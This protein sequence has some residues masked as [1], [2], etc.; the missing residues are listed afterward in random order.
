MVKAPLSPRRENHSR[1]VCDEQTVSRVKG[2]PLRRLRK[3]QGGTVPRVHPCRYAFVYLRGA[4]FI[5]SRFVH[6]YN[7]SF[8][9][10]KMYIYTEVQK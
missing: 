6:M 10:Q 3:K 4:F 9:T 7:N 2:R 5:F 8:F 1:A